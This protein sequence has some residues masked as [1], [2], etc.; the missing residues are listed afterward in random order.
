MLVQINRK[1]GAYKFDFWSAVTPENISCDN[2]FLVQLAAAGVVEVKVQHAGGDV[3][4][5]DRMLEH[6]VVARLLRSI[7]EHLVHSCR[8]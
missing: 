7:H 5:H 6:N 3:D 4:E 8:I 1:C 2:S